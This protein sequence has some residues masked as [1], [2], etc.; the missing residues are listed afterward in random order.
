MKAPR[1]EMIK[2]RPLIARVI[3]SAG[4]PPLPKSFNS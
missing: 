4:N 2:K 3:P 1:L